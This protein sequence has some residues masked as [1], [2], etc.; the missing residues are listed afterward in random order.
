[1]T[2]VWVVYG[3]NHDYDYNSQ[4]L[5]GAYSSEALAEEAKARDVKRWLAYSKRNKKEDLNFNIECVEID[6]DNDGA[7]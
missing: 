3:D 1:M 6:V 2:K 5:V 4:W 7:A